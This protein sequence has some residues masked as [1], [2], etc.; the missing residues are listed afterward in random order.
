M[1]APRHRGHE[2]GR[3][4]SMPDNHDGGRQ[5]LGRRLSGE[6]SQAR[7]ESICIPAP[8]GMVRQDELPTAVL[9]F[10]HPAL[11]GLTFTYQAPDPL[12]CSIVIAWPN[13]SPCRGGARCRGRA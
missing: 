12:R 13:L 7:D 11:T 4:A 9:R 10:P 5:V 8:I 3:P 2:P 6:G 1:Q